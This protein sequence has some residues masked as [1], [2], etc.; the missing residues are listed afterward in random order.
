MGTLFNVAS[1][2]IMND[3]GGSALTEDLGTFSGPVSAVLFGALDI[4]GGTPGNSYTDFFKVKS[5]GG[6]TPT[7]STPEPGSIILLGTILVG[8]T[9]AIRKRRS[10]V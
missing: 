3:H 4:L 1:S 5:M 9:Y 10:A 6:T 8:V 7:I 2:D